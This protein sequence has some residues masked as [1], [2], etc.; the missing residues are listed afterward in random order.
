M[1]SSSINKIF[2]RKNISLRLTMEGEGCTTAD[3]GRRRRHGG[4]MEE[5]RG[6][7]REEDA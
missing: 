1:V 5:A 4:R 6:Q 3:G 7:L 2:R